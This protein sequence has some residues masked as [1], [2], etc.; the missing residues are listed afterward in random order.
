MRKYK[1]SKG[2]FLAIE[3]I[4]GVGKTTQVIRLKEQ[5]SRKGLPIS[6][7]KEPTEGQ[8]GQMIREI[9]KKGRH[10]YTPTEELK[11][12]ILDRKE[13]LEKNI[14]PALERNELVIIDR[15]YFSNIAYQGALGLDKDYILNENEKFALKPDLTIILDCAVRVGLSRIMHSRNDTPNHF[16]KEDYLE[17]VKKIFLSMEGPSIQIINSTPDEDTVFNHVKNIV[18]DVIAPFT[19]VIEDQ[20]DLFSINTVNKHVNFSKN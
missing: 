8:Y 12:F 4:D 3:G 18:Q 14:M 1:L 5:F 17:N 10:L 7:F 16:E 15:Y 2:I 6:T 20:A 9:A 11:L 19:F 13:D